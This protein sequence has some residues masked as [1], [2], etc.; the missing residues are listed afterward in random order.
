MFLTK[1]QLISLLNCWCESDVKFSDYIDCLRFIKNKDFKTFWFYCGCTYCRFLIRREVLIFTCNRRKYISRILKS[2]F[3][4]WTDINK[5][6]YE[7]K[8]SV[9]GS[10]YSSH[11]MQFMSRNFVL[12]KNRQ[13]TVCYPLKVSLER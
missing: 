6:K 9:F 8:N 5:W 11:S 4:F 12:A 3:Y 2:C 13:S 1:W 10:F 7:E